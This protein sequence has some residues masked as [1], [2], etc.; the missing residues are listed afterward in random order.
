[1]GNTLEQMGPFLASL[2]IHS[3]LVDASSA[4]WLGAA[5]VILRVAYAVT[6]WSGGYTRA[7]WFTTFPSYFIIAYLYGAVLLRLGF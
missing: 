2:W 6:M 3:W 5:Y 7:L 1:M 4:V